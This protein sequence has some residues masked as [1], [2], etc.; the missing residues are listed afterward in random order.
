MRVTA[1]REQAIESA[2]DIIARKPLYLDTE[3][4]GMKDH[5][6]IIEICILNWDGEVLLDSLVNPTRMIPPDATRIHG[7]TYSMVRNSPHWSEVW[8]QVVQLVSGHIVGIY[9][10][11]FDIRMMKQSHN[12][13]QIKWDSSHI[14]PFCIMKLYAKFYGQ[15]NDFKRSYRW[16][17]LEN[18]G[19]QCNINL[20]NTHRAKDD[21]L[22][23]RAVLHHIAGVSS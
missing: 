15:W 23:T 6:E 16:Q 11:D 18:A 22:L 14:Q 19:K 7:I 4:T 20:P 1:D 10:A 21:T 13:N 2:K 9:N 12:I 17:S 5:D 8:E 3:T